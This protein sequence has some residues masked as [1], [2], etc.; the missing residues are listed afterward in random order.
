MIDLTSKPEQKSSPLPETI[1]ALMSRFLRNVLIVLLIAL[2][3]A[4]SSAFSLSARL[5]LT[6][7]MLLAISTITRCSVMKILVGISANL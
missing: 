2:N 4:I 7:A 6:W 5:S 1:T 3:I